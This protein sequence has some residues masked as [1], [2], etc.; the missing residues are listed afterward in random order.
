MNNSTIEFFSSYILENKVSNALKINNYRLQLLGIEFPIQVNESG[1]ITSINSLKLDSLISSRLTYE[2]WSLDHFHSNMSRA[3]GNH[4]ENIVQIRKKAI[5]LLV[6]VLA[7]LKTKTTEKEVVSL[8]ENI[9]KK[10]RKIK[11]TLDKISDGEQAHA[12]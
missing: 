11:N 7:E 5:K 10:K 12:I 1:G 8:I 9:H 4:E 2:I 6:S 3:G